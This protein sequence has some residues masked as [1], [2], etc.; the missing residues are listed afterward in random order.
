MSH[1]NGIKKVRG[2]IFQNCMMEKCWWG[3][4]V[5]IFGAGVGILTINHL[6]TLA[7]FRVSTEFVPFVEKCLKKF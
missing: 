1:K 3:S 4:N 7:N 2:V 5:G 6:A